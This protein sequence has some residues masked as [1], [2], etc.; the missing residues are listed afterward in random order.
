MKTEDRFGLVMRME[1]W[2]VQT[3]I[4][5]LSLHIHKDEQDPD[6]ALRNVLLITILN[7][8]IAVGIIRERV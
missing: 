2:S 3:N 1:D 8:S 4:F 7:L 6:C 5:Q